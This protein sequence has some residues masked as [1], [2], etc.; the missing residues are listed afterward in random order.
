LARLTQR[1]LDDLYVVFRSVRDEL[2]TTQK[3]TERSKFNIY[4]YNNPSYIQETKSDQETAAILTYFE[5]TTL[6]VPI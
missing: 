3:N 6:C 4:K 2:V 1:F 5:A